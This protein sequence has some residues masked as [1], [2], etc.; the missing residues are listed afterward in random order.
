MRDEVMS[1]SVGRDAATTRCTLFKVQ[2][3]VAR[4][5]PKS[6]IVNRIS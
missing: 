2:R 3:R 1:G 6:H 4:I 5:R